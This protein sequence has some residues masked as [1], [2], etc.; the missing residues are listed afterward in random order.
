MGYLVGQD[1][2]KSRK[3]LILLMFSNYLILLKFS[4]TIG[5]H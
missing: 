3:P 4:I 1:L 2:S 5:Y